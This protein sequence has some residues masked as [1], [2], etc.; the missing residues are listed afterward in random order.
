[1]NDRPSFVLDLLGRLGCAWGVL[2]GLMGMFLW[3]KVL[4]TV[5]FVYVLVSIWPLLRPRPGAIL[6]A[7]CS[8]ALI[9]L[10]PLASGY[11]GVLR[12]I[13]PSLVAAIVGFT[14]PAIGAMII[15]GVTPPARIPAASCF[16]CGYPLAG[17]AGTRCPECGAINAPAMERE[18]G[19]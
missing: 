1:M 10:F 8:V 15:H 19:E 4:G 5:A 12:D 11:F 7:R 16:T 6:L 9:A 17:L 2:F 13:L 18:P 14:P 3:G